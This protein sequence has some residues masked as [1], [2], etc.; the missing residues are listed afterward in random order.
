MVSSAIWEK[1]RSE[2]EIFEQLTS[3]CFSKFHEKPYYYLLIIYMK[4]DAVTCEIVNFNINHIEGKI[5]Q[6]MIG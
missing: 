2:F 1:R 3:V 5:T 4:N 6:N